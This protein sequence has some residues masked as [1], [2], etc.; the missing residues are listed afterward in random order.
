[1]KPRYFTKNKVSWL[2]ISFDVS[3]TPCK[4][5]SASVFF[6]L[7]ISHIDSKR[8]HL[9]IAPTKAPWSLMIIPLLALV[10]RY[11]LSISTIAAFRSPWAS[12]TNEIKIDSMQ[13]VGWGRVLLLFCNHVVVCS[14]HS[15]EFRLYHCV[16][17]LETLDTH[18][19]VVFTFWVISFGTSSGQTSLRS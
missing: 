4:V 7:W 11:T 1:M 19:V 18:W 8:G 13:A 2:N 14:R 10:Y 6:C 17:N 12:I 16:S 15:R 5:V 3:A 9:S